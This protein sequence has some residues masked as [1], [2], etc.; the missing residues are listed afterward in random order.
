M[1]NADGVDD[2]DVLARSRKQRG[3]LDM[4]QLDGIVVFISTTNGTDVLL[5]CWRHLMLMNLITT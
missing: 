3:L 2:T 5:Q 4:W 1:S